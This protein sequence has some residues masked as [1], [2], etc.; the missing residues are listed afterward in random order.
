V[1]K[2]AI[3]CTTALKALQITTYWAMEKVMVTDTRRLILKTFPLLQ[4]HQTNNTYA[5]G[6]DHLFEPLVV[7]IY[8][9]L[10]SLNDGVPLACLL[11]RSSDQFVLGPD[12][13]L[14]LLA[15]FGQL[16][17]AG[18][19]FWM[20]EGAA[21][22]L[23]FDE[24]ELSL[25]QVDSQRLENANTETRHKNFKPTDATRVCMYRWF[26][27]RFLVSRSFSVIFTV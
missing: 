6:G 18:D 20:L 21:R 11:F 4:K 13:L 12:V 25:L 2:P 3:I 23:V 15:L 10:L 17:D 7:L 27:S 8:T 9:R 24:S 5:T 22:E 19:A 26:T 1:K 16:A 14:Q